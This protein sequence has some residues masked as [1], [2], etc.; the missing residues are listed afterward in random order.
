LTVLHN[1]CGF[2]QVYTEVGPKAHQILTSKCI[3]DIYDTVRPIFTHGDYYEGL[4]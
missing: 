1:N 4:D 2:Q 3:D